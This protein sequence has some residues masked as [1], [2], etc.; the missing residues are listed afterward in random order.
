[1]TEQPLVTWR[2]TPAP[3]TRIVADLPNQ[4]FASIERQNNRRHLQAWAARLGLPIFWIVALGFL[5]G[6]R[7]LWMW[8]SRNLLDLVAFTIGPAL[9]LLMLAL[10]SEVLLEEYLSGAM[11]RAT[12]QLLFWTPRVLSLP[13]GLMLFTLTGGT[14]LEM[15]VMPVVLAAAWRWDWFGVLTFGLFAMWGLSAHI[16]YVVPPA[17][18]LLVVGIPLLIG[19]LLTLSWAYHEEVRRRR[20]T[21]SP[22]AGRDTQGKAAVRLP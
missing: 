16:S 4:R 20:R 21:D 17:I 11:R 6:D 1:M 8:P 13:Y 3:L 12:R 5:I 9:A 2:R 15:F 14:L 7:A 18:Y 22:A 10:G 19:A